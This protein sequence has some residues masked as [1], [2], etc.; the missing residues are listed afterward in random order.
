MK[1]ISIYV[2]TFGKYASGSLAGAWLNVADY[3]GEDEFFA[4]CKE[5][6]KDEEGPEFMFQDF[7]NLPKG[8]AG[9]CWINPELFE[10]AAALADMDESEAEAYGIFC[11][12]QGTGGDL[13]LKHFRECYMGQYD[14]EEDFAEQFADECGYLDQIPQNLRYYFDF[15][16]FARDLFLDG[17][18]F[19]AGHVFDFNR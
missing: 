7:E 16:K 13:S 18:Y 15:E 3:A 11:D 6:H 1:S 2:G 19:D 5:L 12:Y 10:M 14:S 4:A 8:M 9:E 17:F